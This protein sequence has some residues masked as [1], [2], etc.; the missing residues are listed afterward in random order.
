[1]SVAKPNPPRSTKSILSHAQIAMRHLEL[2]DI[3]T[4]YSTDDGVV[5]ACQEN[6]C[7]QI[8][9]GAHAHSQRL[10]LCWRNPDIIAHP[11]FR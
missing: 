9:L 4:E 3:I 11:R 10:Y 8:G 7:Q 6:V 2:N 1:M 5:Y